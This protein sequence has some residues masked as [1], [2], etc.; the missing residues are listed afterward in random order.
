MEADAQVHHRVLR[1]DEVVELV[2]EVGAHAHVRVH[3]VQLARELVAAGLLQKKRHT[4]ARATGRSEAAL[5]SK[6]AALKSTLD[7]P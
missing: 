4:R 5:E 3:S 1:L 2:V 7:L 6:G